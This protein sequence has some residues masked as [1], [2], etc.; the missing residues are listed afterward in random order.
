MKYTLL[1]ALAF[2]LLTPDAGLAHGMMGFSSNYSGPQMMQYVE[3]Q[4][5][6]NDELHEEMEELMVKMLAGDLTEAEANRMVELM[7]EY[8]GPMGMMMNRISMMSGSTF[9]DGYS[10]MHW[11]YD[12]RGWVNAWTWFMFLVAAVWFAVGTLVIVWLWKQIQ[13][14]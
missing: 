7:D 4:A 10:A 8:S 14:K 2:V 11:G 1:I 6:Q 5:L 9:G 3:D 13:K 12:G